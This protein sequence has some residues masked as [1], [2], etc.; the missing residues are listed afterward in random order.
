M[1][2]LPAAA[3][4]QETFPLAEGTTLVMVTDGLVE[5]PTLPLDTGLARA[6][7][8]TAQGTQERASIESTADARSK[9][10]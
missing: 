1:G 5:G 10:L 8:L 2:V 3:Y 6:G 7:A 9:R 4:P